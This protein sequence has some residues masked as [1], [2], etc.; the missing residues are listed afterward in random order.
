MVVDKSVSGKS[1]NRTCRPLR[2]KSPHHCKPGAL[3]GRHQTL[4]CTRPCCVPGESGRRPAVFFWRVAD[5]KPA[6]PRSSPLRA[7]AGTCA[8][9]RTIPFIPRRNPIELER[10]GRSCS[11]RRRDQFR[12]SAA[13]RGW[14]SWRAAASTRARGGQGTMTRT[15]RAGQDWARAD[16]GTASAAGRLAGDY[17]N[18]RRFMAGAPV[19]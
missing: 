10:G 4:T 8:R 5:A 11:S 14:A 18:G 2:P 1:G 6:P 17:R 9:R 19:E 15:V 12:P 13:C 16:S 7:F 3:A